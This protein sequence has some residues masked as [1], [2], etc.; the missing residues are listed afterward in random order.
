MVRL[1]LVRPPVW[2]FTTI[3]T[4]LKEQISNKV[5]AV[6]QISPQKYLRQYFNMS[7]FIHFLPH[8]SHLAFFSSFAPFIISSPPVCLVTRRIDR[9][10]ATMTAKP[11]CYA[12]HLVYLH[13]IIKCVVKELCCVY[14]YFKSNLIVCV[15]KRISQIL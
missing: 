7:I 10:I 14:N 4:V 15:C 5:E 1:W 6:L 2:S 8:V 11:E 13:L 12:P 9:W 3:S